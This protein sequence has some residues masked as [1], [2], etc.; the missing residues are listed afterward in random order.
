MI[1]ILLGTDTVSKAIYIKEKCAKSALEMRK[2]FLSNQLPDLR[3]LAEPVLFGPKTAYV[4]ES[5]FKELDAE[6]LLQLHAESGAEVVIVED[7]I[8]QRKTVNK[9]LLHDKRIFV[10]TF[11]PPSG[12][13][14]GK[15]LI[16]HAD[17]LGARLMPDAATAIQDALSPDGGA[18]PVNAAQNE[19]LKLKSLA[20]GEAIT[21]QMVADIVSSTIVIDV[22]ELLDAIGNKDRQR[23]LTLLNAF[24]ASGG[25]EKAKSIQLGSLLADQLRNIALVK[26]AQLR[27]IPNQE[28][29]AK[30]GW[31]QGRLY[32]MQKLSRN[33]TGHQI[34]DSL[35]KIESLDI[36]LKSSTLPPHVVLDLIIVHM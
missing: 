3:S 27:R 29:L 8:D 31:K 26:D 22:F 21:R 6:Q 16:R 32:I 15:W 19:L 35:S 2:I 24:F 30:T 7:S 36:E 18:F 10:K 12:A 14:A 23:A 1:T 11:E 13:A 34:H 9:N 17:A 25:D 4:F 33:F 20:G 28:I 5:C